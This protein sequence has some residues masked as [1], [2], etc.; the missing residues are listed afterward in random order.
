M[1]SHKVVSKR[2]WLARR[3]LA[4]PS[5]SQAERVET[6]QHLKS[7]DWIDSASTQAIESKGWC[8]LQVASY[9]TAGAYLITEELVVEPC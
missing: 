7:S 2:H 3:C 8:H 4:D 6:D 5:R 9:L 1:P